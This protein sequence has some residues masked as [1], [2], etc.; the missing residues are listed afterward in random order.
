[1]FIGKKNLEFTKNT[2]IIHVFIVIL[3]VQIQKSY[4]FSLT[5]DFYHTCFNLIVV[6]LVGSVFFSF[7]FSTFFLSRDFHLIL[8]VKGLQFA[9]ARTSHLCPY[10]FTE[11]I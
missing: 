8:V 10:D 4:W 7:T 9:G 11:Y 1:M 2:H 6:V 5:T 3:S